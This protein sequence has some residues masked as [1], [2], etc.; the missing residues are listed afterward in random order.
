MTRIV[1]LIAA[2]SALWAVSS[3]C[4]CN[5]GNVDIEVPQ[6]VC[7]CFEG[8]LMPH[9]LFK[10]DELVPMSIWF[11][12]DRVSFDT[13]AAMQSV[14]AGLGIA[15]I[16]FNFTFSSPNKTNAIFSM[17][18]DS[19]QLLLW[20][21]YSNNSWLGNCSI[22]SVWEYVA[23]PP[24]TGTIEVDTT[25]VLFRSTDGKIVI[26]IGILSWLI[27]AAV[28][29]VAVV[30]LDM[31]FY[32]NNEAEVMNQQAL[33]YEHFHAGRT[34]TTHRGRGGPS[35]GVP[36]GGDTFAD[37]STGQRV[38]N[39]SVRQKVQNP[40]ITTDDTVVEDME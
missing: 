24:V 18:G 19:A 2:L 6:C 40:L 23:L 15:E 11:N 16:Y 9:C 25:M 26:T 3:A 17:R 35:E 8:Y 28:C 29:T 33:E 39:V 38:I 22:D 27:G 20:D 12:V 4:E 37:Y 10:A 5:N 13:D 30:C 34:L 36:R 21:F 1:V 31:L 7:S 32:H 14:A